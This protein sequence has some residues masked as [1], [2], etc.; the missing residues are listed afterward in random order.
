MRLINQ[1][2]NFDFDASPR[3]SSRSYAGVF[4]L[5]SNNKPAE[6]RDFNQKRLN[7]PSTSHGSSIAGLKKESSSRKALF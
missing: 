7:P 4:I 1:C 5:F 6:Q 3:R 2:F